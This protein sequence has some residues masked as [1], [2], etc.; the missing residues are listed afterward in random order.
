[1]EKILIFF[2]A[3]FAVS[4]RITN[5]ET[6]VGFVLRRFFRV[7]H[8]NSGNARTRMTPVALIVEEKSNQKGRI[9]Y[10]DWR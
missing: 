4:I 9:T 10:D 6:M 2:L 8:R 3:A 5:S 7:L 1:M